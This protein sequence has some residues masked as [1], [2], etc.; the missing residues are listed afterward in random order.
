M[1]ILNHLGQNYYIP[2]NIIKQYCH[3]YTDDDWNYTTAYYF[4]KG[5][6]KTKVE[7]GQQ[8]PDYIV[9]KLS[10]YEPDTFYKLTSES[11]GSKLFDYFIKVKP[12]TPPTI[13]IGNG[14]HKT[15]LND[16]LKQ[17]KEEEKKILIRF[18]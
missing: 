10:K 11:R 13:T 8:K 14:E 4:K 7:P 15:I 12:K 5:K 3:L 16:K 18:E 17:L 9:T 6:K 1:P 2:D